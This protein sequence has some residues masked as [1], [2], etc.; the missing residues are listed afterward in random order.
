M[1]WFREIGSNDLAVAAV[2]CLSATGVWFSFWFEHRQKVRDRH[3]RQLGELERLRERIREDIQPWAKEWPE[4]SYDPEWYKPNWRVR[5]FESGH[6]EEFNRVVMT[7]DYPREL[8]VGLVRL[9]GA[10]RRFHEALERQEELRRNVPN[11]VTQNLQPVYAEARRRTSGLSDEEIAAGLGDE[12]AR[13]LQDYFQGHRRIHVEIIGERGGNGLYEAWRAVVEQIDDVQAALRAGRDTWWYVVGHAVA[14]VLALMGGL[15][16][17][18]FWASFFD[19]HFR[20][21]PAPASSTAASADTSRS[22]TDSTAGARD[23]S[24]VRPARP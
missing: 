5:A 22:V 16:V 14:L 15:L 23:T 17:V 1:H 24:A 2:A 4:T 3:Q 6:V 11:V 18:N 10:A 13:W 20:P 21:A 9:E 12:G 19:D 7:G 8:T